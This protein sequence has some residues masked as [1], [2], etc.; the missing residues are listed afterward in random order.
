[1]RYLVL[2]LVVLLVTACSSHN[3]LE[4]M[5]GIDL[6]LADYRKA[7]INTIDYALDFRIPQN[8][9]QAIQGYEVLT[10]NLL[11]LEQDLQLDFNAPTEQIKAIIVNARS[12]AIDHRE[13]H[14]IIDKEFLQQG[15]NTIEVNFFVGE[16]SLNRQEEFLYTL[17]VPD[18]ARTAFP[19]FDQPNL[20]ARYTLE[21]DI[22][23]TWNAFSNA[24]IELMSIKEGRKSITFKQ[25]DLMS[26]Y[27]FSFVA[28]KFQ[29]LS[30]EV[31][32]RAMTMLHR[33]TDAEKV[34]RNK[35][36]IFR[37]HAA[38]LR[39]MEGYTGIKYPFQKFDF[40]LIPGFQYGGMEHV[41][42]IQYR[43]NSLF[44]DEDPSQN[45]L[46]SR[47]SL[48]GHETAHMWF[49]DLVTMDW[50]ND[51]WTKE[52]FA[53]FMAAKM[54]NP[55][56]PEIDHEL[57]FLLRHYPA[58]YGVDRTAGAN[59]IRQE[60][61]NLNEA[62][63]MYG[64]IIYN[65]APIM[66]R[67]LEIMLGEQEFRAG[68]QRYLTTYANKNATWPNLIEILDQLTPIDLEKWSAVWVNAPG[69]PHFDWEVDEAN[70]GRLTQSDPNGAK[71]WS[72][73]LSMKLF[74]RDDVKELQLASADTP[75]ET[76]LG[77]GWADAQ[78]IMNADGIGYGLFPMDYGL[79]REKWEVLTDLEKGT[80]LINAYEQ[81]VE[82]SAATDPTHFSPSTYLETL[83]WV[84]L[85]EKNQ[86]LIGQV[87]R[88]TQTVFWS[89][90]TPEQQE[91][92]APDLERTLFHVMNDR[93][94]DPAIKKTYFNA[95]RSIA[96]AGN[97]VDRLYK[98]WKGEEKIRGLRLSENDLISLSAMLAIKMPEKSDALIAEQAEAI[99]N[100][101]AKKRYEFLSAALSSD[102]ATRDAKFA[103]FQEP[104]NREIESWVL[105]A[106]GYLH[107]PLRLESSVAYI[108]PSLE[109]LQEI[110]VTGDI[111]F[112]KRWL[113]QTLNNHSSDEAIEVVETFLAE[114]P[115]YNAQLK[116]KILQAV[117]FAKRANAVK[118]AWADSSL[119][120]L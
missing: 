93:H 55:S 48:I 84:M 46:L 27:L 88:Q 10:F 16:S 77:S 95:Y 115:D 99:K 72:Q 3:E 114:H 8:K 56:F 113:D 116:M 20:K 47:A 57:N 58:A 54:V 59:A 109:L 75:F 42:A 86:L 79:I 25:S 40:A 51:V 18:R 13:E 22:P 78:V 14:I 68:M 7:N 73:L 62:G 80:L 67:Q 102:K 49:G 53:N 31:E 61:Q 34:A 104:E 37:L 74:Q 45:Q 17:F 24:P 118:K 41:G 4:V 35:D 38:A 89:L 91:Q 36:E 97:N 120:P 12:H 11:S 64:A 6:T 21:L 94:D 98:I 103:S 110:Q 117:D 63:Q 108:A 112:P 2:L 96:M 87:L 52:V 92:M 5:K 90:L 70:T 23:S 15:F 60:L 28:G 71:A 43:A 39:W 83:K 33:E 1:M 101:D 107:H 85:R 105:S 76:N 81:L 82:P 26:S 29:A 106:L 111:F 44:L 69:R 32:G 119:E 100:P 19:V 66:M 30:T 65:K 50:F 9:E